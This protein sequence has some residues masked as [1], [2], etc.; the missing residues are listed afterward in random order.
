MCP[1]GSLPRLA[2]GGEQP[3]R[4]SQTMR[5]VLSLRQ[6]LLSG[7][8]APG[9]RMSEIPLV[10]RLGVSRTPLR[11]ALAKLEHEGL[12]EM[13]AGGGYVVKQFTQAD[14]DDA[15]E[16][17]GVLEGTAVRLAAE[18]G[19]RRRHLTALRACCARMDSVVHESD[20]D[21]FVQ[22]M[23]LNRKFHALLLEA[24]QSPVLERAL[25]G[26]VSLPFASPSAFVLAQAELPE[27]REILVVAQNHHR[28]IVDAIE[29]REGARAEG[30]AREHARVS[31]RNLEV[32]L[33]TRDALDRVPGGSLI[34]L[35]DKV[36]NQR[37][38]ESHAV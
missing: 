18:R 17:R 21:S 37:A 30:L 35:P 26:V 24:A 32:V 20:V 38:G 3:L 28:G 33:N 34:K 1:A 2:G 13:L 14:I 6:L 5:A 12:L 19:A 31:R 22:Y 9:T 25:E 4:L 15:I 16:L 23:D 11:L 10:E 27:S 7:E 8:F 36:E 29:N